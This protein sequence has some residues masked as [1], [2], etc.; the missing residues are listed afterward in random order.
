[1]PKSKVVKEEIKS[2][3]VQ[4]KE[5]DEI[6]AQ[7]VADAKKQVE[8]ETSTIVERLQ[9][10]IDTANASLERLHKENE[11]I[12]RVKRQAEEKSKREAEEKAAA[13]AKAARAQ[14]QKE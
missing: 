8:K 10:E 3:E 2:K 7:A 4:E 12:K 5:I 1:M 11:E 9:K 6:K 14:I 13:E